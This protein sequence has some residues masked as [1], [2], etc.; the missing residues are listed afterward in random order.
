MTTCRNL[1]I[2][3]AL[4]KRST[5]LGSLI[6]DHLTW[7]LIFN[8]NLPECFYSTWHRISVLHM[9]ACIHRPNLAKKMAIVQEE[10]LSLFNW[11]FL[12]LFGRQLQDGSLFFMSLGWFHPSEWDITV[13]FFCWRLVSHETLP[14]SCCWVGV[15]QTVH[16]NVFAVRNAFLACYSFAGY[17]Q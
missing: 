7:W 13:E 2:N 8:F 6:K 5:V 14:R 17:L 11:H 12:M 15:G 16:D 9:P 4:I 1:C 3:T 10:S